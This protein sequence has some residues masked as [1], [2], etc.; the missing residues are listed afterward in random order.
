[1]HHVAPVVPFYNLQ[2]AQAAL[3]QA[4]PGLIR[5]KNFSFGELWRILKTCHFYDLHSGYYKDSAE[6][7]AVAN[8]GSE[9]AANT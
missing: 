6:R 7:R 5:E 3:K 9:A 8:P 1:V 4:Y 2:K